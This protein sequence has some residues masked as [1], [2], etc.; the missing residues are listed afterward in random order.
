MDN[1]FNYFNDCINEVDKLGIINMYNN[2]QTYNFYDIF[3]TDMLFNTIGQFPTTISPPFKINNFTLLKPKFHPFTKTTVVS[4]NQTKIYKIYIFQNDKNKILFLLDV[5]REFYFQ[6]KFREHITNNNMTNIIVPEIHRYGII[7]IETNNEIICF[8]EMN[9]YNTSECNL[10][11]IV[12]Q[13]Q[14]YRNKI[15][16][17]HDYVKKYINVRTVISVIEKQFEIYHNDLLTLEYLHR[18]NN[19]ITECIEH[20][21]EH[22]HNEFLSTFINNAIN[23]NLFPSNNKYILIDFE[24]SSM[25]DNDNR[26]CANMDKC[27]IYHIF[28]N[29][30]I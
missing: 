23:Y 20:N 9:Y 11:K 30:I 10:R 1:Y 15:E 16:I 17:I 6:I 21:S 3:D 19:Q 2:I 26:K 24:T 25:I 29:L 22:L 13:E 27:F 12:E 14:T 8:A 28:N 4:S 18:V 7:N 5:L